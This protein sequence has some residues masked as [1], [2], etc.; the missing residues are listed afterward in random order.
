MLRNSTKT[1]SFFLIVTA[2]VI[3]SLFLAGVT[4]AQD[5]AV[6]IA[7]AQ[8]KLNN[9]RLGKGALQNNTTGFD[10]TAIGVQALFSNTTRF[11]FGVATKRAL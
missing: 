7:G 11:F 6:G 4:A 10:N 1:A 9:T 5:N 2:T 3:F 8:S